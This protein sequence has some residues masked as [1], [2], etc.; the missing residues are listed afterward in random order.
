VGYQKVTQAIVKP[1]SSMTEF[2][3]TEQIALF[4]EAGEPLT[5]A[6]D[7]IKLTG[8]TTGTSGDLAASDT[9]NE[10]LAKLEARIVALGG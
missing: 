8:F 7:T 5:L 10:A 6:A 1:Q 2:Q 4:D 3:G 9:I